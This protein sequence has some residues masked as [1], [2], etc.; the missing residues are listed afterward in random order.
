MRAQADEVLAMLGDPERCQVV[1]VTL[2]ETTPVNE[3]IETAYS[4]EERV[5]VR[6]GPIVVNQVDAAVGLPDPDAVSFGRVRAQ[7]DD[8]IAAARFRRERGAAQADEIVRLAAA[9]ALPRIV[10]P[11]RPVAGVTAADIDALAAGIR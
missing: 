6:L 1:L 11:R 3:L 5:G 7:V 2:P 8:A 9:V 4:V 10:L